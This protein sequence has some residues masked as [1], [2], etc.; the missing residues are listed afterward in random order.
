MPGSVARF[1]RGTP[2]LWVTGGALAVLAAGLGLLAAATQPSAVLTAVPSPA[3]SAISASGEHPCAI[4]DGRAYCW[5]NN[6]DGELGNGTT[7]SS[8]VP[9][10]V[11]TSGVLAGKT[12]T[13]VTTGDS[14]ATCALD[15]AGA[16][17]C[18][19]NGSLGL[20]GDGRTLSS[21]LPAAVQTS[22]VLAGKTLTQISAGYNE[23]CALDSVG[24]AFCWGN[25]LNGELGNGG[26]ISS[27]VPVAVKTG[28][29]LAGKTLTQVS[30]GDT[31]ACALQS[32]GVAYCWGSNE[33]GELGNGSA[34]IGSSVPVVVKSLG[35]QPPKPPS[36]VTAKAG[37][38]AA[39][40]RWTAPAS[41]GTGSLTGYTATAAPSGRTCTANHALT[42]TITHLINGTTYHITV[43]TRTST[44]RSV[45]STAA[46]VIPHG[47][48]AVSGTGDRAP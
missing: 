23:T 7:N 13:Q 28:G 16:A 1:L 32:G 3:R 22:G 44:S 47:I 36:H 2:W 14:L 17:F 24:A 27:S 8:S 38:S 12:L 45:P 25:N 39:T 29:V 34:A 6:N 42:C 31:N 26:S 21:T 5:G 18:W 19:G 33:H 41:L 37:D 4:Q 15:T 40:V 35:P 30:A 46:T 20:L 9:V 43:I 11:K 48:A 10:A